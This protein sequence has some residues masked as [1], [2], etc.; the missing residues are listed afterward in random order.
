MRIT[1]AVVA[2]PLLVVLL[3][4]LSLRAADPDAERF[5]HA[6]AELDRFELLEAEL[7]RDVLSA[8]AGTLRNYDPLVQETAALDESVGRLQQAAS[9]DAATTSLIDRLA[10]MVQHQEDLVEQ[11]KSNNALLQNSMA[12]IAA[13]SGDESGP[14]TP[15]VSSLAAAMLR[16][17]LDTSPTAAGEVQDRL[18]QLKNQ[19]ISDAT[20]SIDALLAHGRLLHDLLPATDSVLEAIVSEPQAREQ[21]ALR[22]TIQTLQAESR[23]TARQFRV[24]LYAASLLL[25]GILVHVGL[26]LRARRC[27]AELGSNTCWQASP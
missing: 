10:T 1:P 24:F 18:D 16:F 8:R 6:L 2:I 21:A 4:W 15:L 5:D 22:A 11:F 25:V 7:N 14:L 9:F 19:S 17:T 3:T 27:V 12:Y 20:A 13:F 23:Q 26:R